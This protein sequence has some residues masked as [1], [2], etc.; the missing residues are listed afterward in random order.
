MPGGVEECLGDLF[1]EDLSVLLGRGSLGYPDG[2][3]R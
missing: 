1:E 2:T 3:V